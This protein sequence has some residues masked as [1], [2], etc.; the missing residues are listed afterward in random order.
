MSRGVMRVTM[1]MINGPYFLEDNWR[2][3]EKH[4]CFCRKEVE[5]TNGLVTTVLK[6]IYLLFS[7]FNNN[8]YKR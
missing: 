1:N 7:Y 6:S 5:M 8:H 3:V 4:G 2:G